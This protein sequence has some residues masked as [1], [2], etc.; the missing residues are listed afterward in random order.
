[1]KNITHAVLDFWLGPVDSDGGY[2]T[3]KF[4][5]NSNDDFDAE[6][7]DKFL[8][9]HH[10]AVMGKYDSLAQDADDYLAVVIVLDQ[11]SRNMFR[12]QSKAFEAD[13][14]ALKWAQRAISNGYDMELST[15][16]P[17]MFFYLPL[18]HSEN[19]T[20]QNESVRLFT[21]MGHEDYITYAVA[22]QKVIEEFGRFPHRNAVLGRIN[23]ADEGI[24]LSKPGAG[25]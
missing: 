6:I 14:I 5:F 25:F 12:G 9:V 20:V 13:E 4:W 3:Q 8:H 22:H 15:P 18:E 11:L 1:M 17:R 23:T 2:K 7:R 24:Y 10:D 21:A 16:S 19:I